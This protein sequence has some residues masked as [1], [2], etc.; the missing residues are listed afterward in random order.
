VGARG[1]DEARDERRAVGGVELGDG[2]EAVAVEPEVREGAVQLAGD[3]AAGGVDEVVDDGAVRTGDLAQVAER[4]VLE[5]RL[6]DGGAG[7]LD[8]VR[9]APLPALPSDGVDLDG[10]DLKWPSEAPPR[11]PPRPQTRAAPPPSQPYLRTGSIA[12]ILVAGQSSPWQVLLV[13]RFA[14]ASLSYRANTEDRAL[15]YPVD[16][17]WIVVVADGTGGISGGARAA[18]LLV[19]GVRRAAP[20]S[21]LPTDAAAWTGLLERLDDEIAGDPEAGETTGVVLAVAS[22]FVVGASCGDSRAYLSTAAGMRELTGH[23]SRKPRLGTGHAKAQPFSADAHGVLV[24]GTDGLFDYTKL[25]DISRTILTAP[26]GGADALVRLV[27]EQY[28][29]LPD[30]IAVVVGWLDE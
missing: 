29:T 17:G 5:A 6:G 25:D 19:S 28:R 22:G 18:E 3:A 13:P 4:V 24:V 23:Q 9:P 27:L 30:D 26:E 8:M 2:V 21:F 1:V 7:V 16:A 11:R 20:T 14:T 12:W 10:V 15:V